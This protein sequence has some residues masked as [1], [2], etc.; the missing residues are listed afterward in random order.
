MYINFMDFIFYDIMVRELTSL[1][2]TSYL[3]SGIEFLSVTDG[4][5]GLS[6]RRQFDYSINRE[7]NKA[8]KYPS[9]LLPQ[10]QF[11]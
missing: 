7:F 11:M 9:D 8:R 4:L 3:F 6:N 2:K 10:P 5:T 1:F